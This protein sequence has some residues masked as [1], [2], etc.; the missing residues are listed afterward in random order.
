[1]NDIESIGVMEVQRYLEEANIELAKAEAEPDPARKREYLASAFDKLTKAFEEILP[2]IDAVKGPTETDL[3]KAS[4]K[5]L[6]Q[7]MAE[8]CKQMTW[9]LVQNNAAIFTKAWADFMATALELETFHE[10][11]ERF[12]LNYGIIYNESTESWR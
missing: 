11:L 8:A 12:A 6:I 7:K 9:G 2:Q 10:D 5:A 4:F 1:M 3:Y